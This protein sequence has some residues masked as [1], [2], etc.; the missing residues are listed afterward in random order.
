MGESSYLR[1]GATL[2][3]VGTQ[4]GQGTRSWQSA[5]LA[6]A[7]RIECSVSL[8]IVVTALCFLPLAVLEAHSHPLVNDE[9]YTLHIAQAPSLRV[10][11]G[12]AREIDLHPPLHYLVER[13]ALWLPLPRWLGARVPSIAAGLV[14]CLCLFFFAAR[15]M[16]QLFGLATVGIFWLTPALDFAWNNR[17]YMLWLACLSGLLVARDVAVR[18]YRRPWAVPLVFGVTLCMV[19]THY[20]GILCVLPFLAG[21][22]VRGVR[23]GRADWPLAGALALPI[24]CGAGC[25]YQLRHMSENA[26]PVARVPTLGMAADMYTQLA[27]TSLI[28]V[29]ICLVVVLLALG[30]HGVSQLLHRREADDERGNLFTS[31]DAVMLVGLL[32]VPL[33]LLAVA[34]MLHMQFWLRYCLAATPAWAVLVVMAVERRLQASRLAAVALVLGSL[35]YMASRMVGESAMPGLGD[36]MVGGRPLIELKDLR[37]ELPIVTASPMTF[38]EMSDREPAAVARRVYYLTDRQAALQYALYTL[39]EN[40][41]KMQRLLQLPSQT[42]EL[43]PFLAEHSSFYVVGNYAQP[44]IWLLRKLEGD[45]LMLDYL[46]KFRSTYESD[47]LYLVSR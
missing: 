47:D 28:V 41:D 46:G 38:V 22:C 23:R 6:L 25:F 36:A 21:E 11:V 13:V 30:R 10:M 40:E 3:V 42:E 24:A 43:Q 8:C 5:G 35:G 34:M 18:P 27:T 19:M 45:G 2:T 33:L 17:P 7:R 39:F 14:A 1:G 16:G 31:Q 20:L 32:A 12:L 9:I 15:R 44:E 4:A 26:F 29:P 37:P